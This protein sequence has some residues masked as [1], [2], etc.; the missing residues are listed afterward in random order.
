MPQISIRIGSR[1]YDLACGEGQEERTHALAAEVDDCLTELRLQMPNAAEA[2]LLV[3][4]AL[5]MADRAHEARRDAEAA[6]TDLAQASDGHDGHAAGDEDDIGQ[7]AELFSRIET[8][9]DSI[10][11][12]VAAA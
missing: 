5:M 2:K 11:Q 7:V 12:K 6:R 1:S 9:I 8:R 10:A 3:F 4:A